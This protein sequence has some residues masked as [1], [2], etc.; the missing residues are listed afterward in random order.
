[1]SRFSIS[2]MNRRS[3]RRGRPAGMLLELLENR[4]MMTVGLDWAV[5]LVASGTNSR[6]SVADVAYDSSGSAYILGDFTG[7]VD[8]QPG[9]GT[10]SLT[11][12]NGKGFVAK[13]SPSGSL[14]WVK[15]FTE[16]SMDGSMTLARVAVDSSEHLIIGGTF[17]GTVDLD[18]SSN[19]S[20]LTA[21]GT[22]TSD[23][24]L[25]AFNLSG[26]LSW[27]KSF[28]GADDDSVSALTFDGAGN[29]LAAGKFAGTADFDPGAGTTN[30]VGPPAGDFFTPDAG[31]IARYAVA[32]GSLVSA[33]GLI[34]NQTVSIYD[35]TVDTQGNIYAVGGFFGTFDADPGS[36]V[37][38]E[39]LVEGANDSLGGFVVKLDST[40]VALNAIT[41]TDTSATV[42]FAQL[43]GI[44]A[45][46]ADNI[47]ITGQFKSSI[48]LS[49]DATLTTSSGNSPFVASYSSAGAYRWGYAPSISSGEGEGE[50][51]TVAETVSATN[52]VFTAFFTGSMD[53]DPGQGTATVASSNGKFNG[54]AAIFSGAGV[55]D[56]AFK[57]GGTDHSEVFAVTATPGGAGFALVGDLRG[58]VDLNPGSGTSN[59]AG[60]SNG[61]GFA[62]QYNFSGT[63]GG[64]GGGTPDLAGTIATVTLPPSILSGSTSSGK[65]TGVLSNNGTGPVPAGKTVDIQLFARPAG[66]LD[67]SGD[68][69]VGTLSNLAVGGLAA[70]Q[71]KS[72]SANV[73]IPGSLGAGEFNIVASFD[74]SGDVE[75]S[76]EANNAVTST[77]TLTAAAAFVDLTATVG[78]TKLPANTVS[79]SGAKIALPIT[80]RNA[81][82]SA[83]ASGAA[84]QV[85]VFA[86]L[87]SA[88]DSHAGDVVVATLN[89]QSLTKLAAG[90]TKAINASVVLDASLAS[91]SYQLYA[92]ID[93]AGAVAESNEENNG[94]LTDLAKPIVVTQ[95]FVDLSVVVTTAPVL[96]TFVNGKAKKV[97]ATITITNN[98]NIALAKLT[99]VDAAFIL[100]TVPGLSDTTLL[101]VVDFSVSSLG[102]GKSKKLAK[103]VTIAAGTP[104]GTW[105]IVGR[106]DGFSDTNENNN[107][108]QTADFTITAPVG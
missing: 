58:T 34:G 17:R 32:S 88:G 83:L 89:N 4:A 31:Y 57:I 24:F 80:I 85:K 106:L 108:G 56:S 14:S 8:F 12:T 1:M 90:K 39:Y 78:S 107:A 76:N 65:V 29:V 95:G 101:S 30:L 38:R 60:G 16:S 41:I 104:A 48:Q 36:G 37:G 64:G 9:A 27:A 100:R 72:Y 51:V 53:I 73:S 45:D 96:T 68:V 63:G 50:H 55:F 42:P 13:Y 93:S 47:Y 79:G 94:V 20:S 69:L 77:Y 6:A 3:S 11:T 49:G 62:A 67:N 105:R 84:V 33:W 15:T 99:T 10:T 81:G 52:V 5:G 66:A 2:R 28:G 75:E 71:S 35:A 54:Y 98:G 82:N 21:A 86:H 92:V 22:F 59:V 103:P 74:S 97:T 102:A 26:E 91:G 43:K 25:A 70:G 40:G 18:P 23:V 44:A 61:A 19:T 46:S 7:T 87:V